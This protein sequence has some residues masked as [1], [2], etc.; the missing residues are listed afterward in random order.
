[1]RL[2]D[3]VESKMTTDENKLEILRRVENG[4]LTVEEGS[5]LI[6]I[7]EGRVDEPESVE[8]MPPMT[9]IEKHEASGCWKAGW[10]MFLVGGAILSGF[11]AYW[12]YQGYQNKGFGWGFWLSWIP[13]LIGIGLMIFGWALLESP[14]MHVRVRA[15]DQTKFA[16]II[17]SMPVPFNIAKWVMQNFGHYMP[18]EVKGYDILEIIDQAEVSIKNGE[19]F[20]VQVDDDEDGSKVEIFIN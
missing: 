18:N 12:I 19:P 7:I 20:Q 15:K 4:T 1:M 10:S 6:A 5:D 3:K 11:S 8:P 2:I 14:W 16:N 9:P 17:F 13:M